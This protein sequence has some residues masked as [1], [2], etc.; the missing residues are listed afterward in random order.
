MQVTSSSRLNKTSMRCKQNGGQPNSQV[1]NRKW[2]DFREKK[3]DFRLS[4]MPTCKWK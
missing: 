3:N 4:L 2:F 1:R